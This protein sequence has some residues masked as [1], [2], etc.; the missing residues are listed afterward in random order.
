MKTCNCEGCCAY[1]IFG[2]SLCECSY[3]GYCD[4]QTPKDSRMQPLTPL[5]PYVPECTCGDG[6]SMPCPLHHPFGV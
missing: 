2:G 4:Y 5:P 6:S 3:M 1:K